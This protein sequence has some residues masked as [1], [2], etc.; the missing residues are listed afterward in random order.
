MTNQDKEK[1]SGTSKRMSLLFVIIFF[2]LA[3]L[4]FRL[5]FIQLSK[6]EKFLASAETNRFINLSIPAPR[7]SIYDRDKVELVG[8]KPAFTITYQVLNGVGQNH[9]DLIGELYQIFEMTPEEMYEKMDPKAEKYSLTIARKIISDAKPY[10]V[11]YVREHANE[12][13]GINVVVEP[14]RNYRYSN[15]SSHVLGY[16]NNIAEDDWAAFKDKGYEQNEIVGW[17][18]VEKQYEEYLH[19]S[20]GTLK[21]E[22]NRYYQPLQEKRT[23]EPVKGHD[24]ILTI[25][26]DLQTATEQ[27][28]KEQLVELKRSVNT[29]EHGA[30][31]A[32][33]PKTGEILA[34]ASYPDFDPN[35]YIKG[36]S[37]KEYNEQILP[38]I[39]NRAIQQTYQPGSTIKMSSVLIGLKEGVI[40]PYS[41]LTDSG[42]IQVGWTTGGKPNMI[43]SWQALGYVDPVKA[44][45][46]SSNVFM[47]DIFK[48]LGKYND[49]M[50]N[51]EV[52][53]FLSSYLPESMKK[54][55]AYHAE[56]G[57]GKVKTG[58]DLPYEVEGSVTEEKNPADLAYASIGQSEH[59]TLMQLAQYVSTIANDGKR[60]EPHIVSEII[61][62]DNKSVQKIEPKV[63]NELPYTQEQI[64]L[65]KRGMR[66]V[67]EKPYGTFYSVLHNF[68]YPVAGKTG[69]AETGRGTENS[70]FVGYA[71][72]DNPQVAIAI[73]I[74]D[75]KA[76][77]HSYDSVGPIAQKMFDAFFTLKEQK[78]LTISEGK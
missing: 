34:M 48:K 5:S 70:L 24:L 74:P 13:P 20:N 22:V 17:A 63:L 67:V 32:M 40:S 78:Q 9:M 6:G 18:G 56:F 27:A 49:F 41:G 33:D 4:I 66:D 8:N 47:I 26:K 1:L 12:L 73:I 36:F 45:A 76:N 62:P 46:V 37:T 7:G 44:L 65:V 51:S 42:A 75:N 11:A 69:T 23:E 61:G 50:N 30:A 77:S 28:L 71:P 58:L 14:I 57:L 39:M 72:Y 59:Y 21:V 35:L 38:G 54:I 68:R 2:S 55:L 53:T 25:D 10:Q 60:M 43:S 64:N 15:S 29:V 16:L 3:V 52:N 31:I 19:G